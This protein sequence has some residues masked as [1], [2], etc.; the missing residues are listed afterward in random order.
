MFA[1]IKSLVEKVEQVA[2]QAVIPNPLKTQEG[3][4]YYKG[5]D[6]Q[7]AEFI[8]QNKIGYLE[9]CAIKY[10]CRHQLK[11][12]VEDLLK[13]KHYIDIIISL[14]YKNQI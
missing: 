5:F 12:G 11:G 8:Y 3:G 14:Q 1:R 10:L 13:A 9:G 4:D 6:I 7:P 2:A